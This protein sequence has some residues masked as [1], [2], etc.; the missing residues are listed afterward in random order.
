MAY[1][2]YEYHPTR[3]GYRG[4]I[5]GYRG[6]IGGPRGIYWGGY[7]R[8]YPRYDASYKSRAQTDY[9]D[10]FGDRGRRTPVRV[11]RGRTSRRYDRNYPPRYHT[12]GYDRGYRGA[13]RVRGYDEG[14]EWLW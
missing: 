4:R 12:A 14:T 10:P 6:T 9:G 3:G 8:R 2:D 13:A 1:Y 5:G 7:S 11:I